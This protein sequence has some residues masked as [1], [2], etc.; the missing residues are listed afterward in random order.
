MLHTRNSQGRG[1]RQY[2]RE[3]YTRNV[4]CS[5]FKASICKKPGVFLLQIWHQLINGG[6]SLKKI[7]WHNYIYDKLITTF[8]FFWNIINCTLKFKLT[9]FRRTS[10][11]CQSSFGLDRSTTR[12]TDVDLKIEHAHTFIQFSSELLLFMGRVT[13]KKQPNFDLR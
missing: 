13:C 1:I 2:L 8:K 10:I 9:V 7:I 12:S 4:K 6:S 3:I 5:T 11:V